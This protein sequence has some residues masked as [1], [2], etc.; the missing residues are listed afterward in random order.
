[1]N[2]NIEKIFNNKLK[3]LYNELSNL[4]IKKLNNICISGEEYID[5]LEC[6][7]LDLECAK[8]NFKIKLLESFL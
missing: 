2:T 4:N 7:L 1:M 6:K 3:R 5:T 8:I